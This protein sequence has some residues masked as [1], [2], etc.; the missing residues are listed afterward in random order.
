MEIVVDAYGEDERAMGWNCYLEDTL[1]FPFLGRCV[2]ERAVSPL[3]VGDEVQVIG[4]APSEECMREVFVTIQWDWKSGLA[5]PLAQLQ[6]V[7]GGDETK[8]AVEDWRYWVAMG[9]R[10]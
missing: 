7:H 8:Q 6:V 3:R 10:F 4:M 5:V 1:D 9:Y 2:A